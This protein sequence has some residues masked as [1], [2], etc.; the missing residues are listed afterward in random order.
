MNPED[1]LAMRA[2][3]RLDTLQTFRA[4]V[5]RAG[6]QEGLDPAVLADLK[7]VV[8]EA[9]TNIV[10]H[11]YG[12]DGGTV[13]LRIDR[14]GSDVVVLIRDQAPPFDPDGVA[15]PEL[16]TAL[17]SRQPGGMGIFLMRQ[18]MDQVEFRPLP[19]EGNELKLVKHLA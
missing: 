6:A 10:L 2:E 15:D 5:D 12:G 18:M 8:D 1:S 17:A 7:L 16:N 4:F 14:E 3:A 13:E 19:G 9:I 11:G